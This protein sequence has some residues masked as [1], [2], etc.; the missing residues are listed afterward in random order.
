[1]TGSM[2]FITIMTSF[3]CLNILYQKH[4]QAIFPFNTH[5]LKTTLILTSFH[6]RVV[7]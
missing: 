1:M 2:V 6:F 3:F 5:M 4:L 7:C